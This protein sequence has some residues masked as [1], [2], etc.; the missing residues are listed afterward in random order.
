MFR[1]LFALAFAFGLASSAHA[2]SSHLWNDGAGSG[3]C[4]DIVNDGAND[5][6]TVV[7][8]G[9]YSGQ[10]WT[11]L[12]AATPGH[13]KLQTDF[14]GGGRCLDVVNDGVNDQVRM[15]SCGNFTGQEWEVSRRH[16]P[17]R[18]FQL[19]NRFTGPLRC[20]AATGEGLRL[21]SCDGSPAQQ[22]SG[23][24]PLFGLNGGGAAS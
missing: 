8:C 20:L 2:Q 23:E 3:Q 9:D 21:R 17:G 12:A 24:W 7:P 1:F 15:A 16:G 11:L 10:A 22:W 19:T 13:V 4:L 5:K 14:T 6:L 18:T